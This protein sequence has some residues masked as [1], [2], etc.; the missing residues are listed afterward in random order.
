MSELQRRLAAD[1]VIIV[2]GVLVALGVDA[3]WEAREERVR[4]AAYLGQ[5]R[6]DLSAT[7]DTLVEMIKVDS[8]ARERA[9][10]ALE[11]LN[12]T[13]LPPSDSLATW[14]L[15]AT[16]SSASF[17]PTMGTVTALVESGELSLVGDESLR[18]E[19]LRY[20]SS[21]TSAL[22]IIDAVD[23]H[24][25]RTLERLGGMLNWAALQR[26]GEAHRWTNDWQSLASDRTFHGALYD[27]RL[28]AHNRLFALRSLAA[29][30]D[31]LQAELDR[32]SR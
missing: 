22:R 31:S 9:D 18:R 7:A 17:Y 20:H 16:S 1:F 6:A 19:I 25:W 15:A 24:M 30:L 10:R 12:S 3:A 29:N 14:I 4:K 8:V 27:L 13:R 21:V 32:S 26:P 2:V 5:L 11:A 23:P 28:A